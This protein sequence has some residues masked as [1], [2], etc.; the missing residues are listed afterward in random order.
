MDTQQIAP[1][2]QQGDVSNIKTPKTRRKWKKFEEDALIKIMIKEISD[3]WTVENG[4]QPGFFILLE[5]DLEKVLP[6]SNLKA[7]PHIESKV[8]A[9]GAIAEDP[10]EMEEPIPIN[11]ATEDVEYM[12]D[13]P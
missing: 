2:I 4:F 7:S 11:P 5:K 10:T 1:E 12:E 13:D 8:R 9:T 3:K 6:G